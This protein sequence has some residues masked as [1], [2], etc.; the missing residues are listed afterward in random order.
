[1]EKFL[2]YLILFFKIA[3]YILIVLLVLIT[4]ISVILWKTRDK[5]KKINITKKRLIRNFEKWFYVN[6]KEPPDQFG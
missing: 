6:E 2:E 3:P 4:N 1:M 5:Q